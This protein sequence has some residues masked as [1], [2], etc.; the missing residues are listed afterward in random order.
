MAVGETIYETLPV[1]HAINY[2]ACED[3]ADYLMKTEAFLL[4][5]KASGK[6]LDPNFCNEQEREAGK[7]SDAQEWAAWER[8]HHA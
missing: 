4:K 6:E 2:A 5:M 7:E 3:M 1:S 8:T